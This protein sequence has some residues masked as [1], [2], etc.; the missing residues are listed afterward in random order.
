MLFNLCQVSLF[1]K[2]TNGIG[3][4]GATVHPCASVGSPRVLN[5]TSPPLLTQ[6]SE[7]VHQ[8]HCLIVYPLLVSKTETLNR[9]NS[10]SSGFMPHSKHVF[11]AICFQFWL[12]FE[13]TAQAYF[14]FLFLP[15]AGLMEDHFHHWIIFVC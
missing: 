6:C 1:L 3:T 8:N 13:R 11:P 5:Y 7:T 12:K 14:A 9:G 10:S 15:Q 4:N 2:E